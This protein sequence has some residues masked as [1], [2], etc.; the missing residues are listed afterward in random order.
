MMNKDEVEAIFQRMYSACG[1]NNDYQLSQY[2]DVTAS[3]V[4][5]WKIAKNPPYK[6]CYEIYERTGH[7]VEWLISGK[8]PAQVKVTDAS[9]NNKDIKPINVP[10]EH[11]VDAYFRSVCLAVNLGYI[12]CEKANDMEELKR[13]GKQFYRELNDEQIIALSEKAK[14]A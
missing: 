12:H 11:F 4:K 14:T 9:T 3:S 6:A 2:F 8:H 10:M 5:G 1:V 13:F 7:T